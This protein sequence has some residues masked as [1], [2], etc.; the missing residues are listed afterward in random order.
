MFGKSE[1]L[2]LRAQMTL[3]GRKKDDAHL[4]YRGCWV[5]DFKTL[6]LMV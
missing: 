5:S 6:L 3:V 2:G 1:E 4:I